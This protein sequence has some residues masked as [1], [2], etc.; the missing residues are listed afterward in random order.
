MSD[1]VCRWG[2]LGTAFIAHKN[3]QAIRNASNCNLVAVASRSVDRA[4]QFIDECQS[5][6]P[7]EQTPRAVGSYEQLL[8]SDDV[9]A[10][11]LPLPTGARKEWAIRAAESGKHVL[12]EKPVGRDASDVDEI[13]AACR[14]NNVQFMD[15]VM[16]MHSRRLD[17]IRRV[18]D[19]GHGVGR[20]KRI[21]S[22]FSFGAPEEFMQDNIRVNSDLEP[23]GCLGDL[24]WYN[25]RFT[26]WAMNEQLPEAVSGRTLSRYSGPGSPA[27]V[28]TEF[29]GELLFADGVSAGFYCSFLTE[30]QQWANISGTKGYLH[31]RDF[32]LPHFGPELSFDVTNAV[33]HIRCCDFNMED[34]T[35]RVAVA[36]YSNSA[37]NAQETNLF[38]DFADLALSGKPDPS[39]GEISLKTQKVVDACLRSARDGGRMVEP[40]A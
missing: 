28:P 21:T 3:W 23:L 18:L 4:R 5:D 7:F 12:S 27:A 6:V 17:A 31:V 33:F 25:L 2:I 11:Y 13:L 10:V 38:R 36:E 40:G 35:R 19:D 26:L 22:Q 15:G 1:R 16:F 8:D 32:V 30:H 20:I 24:G 39:W 34:H 9:D 14:Q 29:S 37:A